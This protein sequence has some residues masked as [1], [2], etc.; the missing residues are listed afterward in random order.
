MLA[1]VFRVLEEDV[2]LPYVPAVRE[3][4]AVGLAA[5]AYLGGSWP[6][7]LMQNSGLGVALNALS[8]LSRM[9]ELPLLLVV[10]WRGE[11]GRDAPEHI[12]AGAIM[13]ELLDLLSIPYR[14]LDPARISEQV[15]EANEMMR[16]TRQPVALVVR[17]GMFP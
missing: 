8:S 16:R 1:G 14:V 17:K 12:Q 5:G 15:Q 10:S 2:H 11:G 13:A 7:V 9:Y 4:V 6:V 3:D